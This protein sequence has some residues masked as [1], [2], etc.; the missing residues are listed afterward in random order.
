MLLPRNGGPKHF[1]RTLL[2]R[3]TLQ[4]STNKRKTNNNPKADVFKHYLHL[5]SNL[6]QTS[7]EPTPEKRWTKR[8]EM[9]HV[10]SFNIN[11]NRYLIRIKESLF[12][13]KLNPELNG[14]ETSVKLKN[15]INSHFQS[16]S[17][18]GIMCL[19]YV[20][21]IVLFY[22]DEFFISP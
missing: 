8:Q 14:S 5:A 6:P 4:K 3:K 18:H 19:K 15:F 10:Y 9:L 7:N 17:P 12:I 11:N 21:L 16:D 13:K 20:S 1:S 22:L 2:T